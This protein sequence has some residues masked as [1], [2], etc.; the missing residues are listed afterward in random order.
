[1][2]PTSSDLRSEILQLFEKSPGGLLGSQVVPLLRQKFADVTFRPPNPKLSAFL[3]EHVP[4]CPM[5]S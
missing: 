5:P 1:M 3:A 2:L 4:V